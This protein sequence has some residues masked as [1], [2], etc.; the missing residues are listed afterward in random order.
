[1]TPSIQTVVHDRQITVSVPDEIPDGTRVAVLV[2]P[3]FEQIGIDESQWSSDA[4]AIKDW[5]E[6]LTTIEPIDFGQSCEFDDKF[7]E[8]NLDA[9]RQQMLGDEASALALRQKCRC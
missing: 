9:V 5:N 6:W 1:M 7:R 4:A 2:V 3:L 8:Y